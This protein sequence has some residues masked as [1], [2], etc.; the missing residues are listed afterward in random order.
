MEPVAEEQMWPH[1]PH[2]TYRHFFWVLK[3]LG[4]KAEAWRGSV[5]WQVLLLNCA[6]NELGAGDDQTQGSCMHLQECQGAFATNP[7]SSII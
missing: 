1:K 4:N 5:S 7:I 3:W 2:V 6:Y